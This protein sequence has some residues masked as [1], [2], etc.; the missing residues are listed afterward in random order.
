MRQ[1]KLILLLST[2]L[3]AEKTIDC[4]QVFDERRE[5]LLRELERIDE[6]QQAF[7][8]F[9]SA[10]NALLDKREEKVKAKEAEVSAILDETKD[11]EEHIQK[12]LDENKK[13][14]EEIKKAK[15]NKIGETFAKM[16]ASKAAPILDE[17]KASKASA[18]L[19]NLDPKTLG[20]LLSKMDPSKASTVVNLIKLGPP[21][22]EKE[23]IAYD[24][25]YLED[26]IKSKINS[27]KPN[28]N[29]NGVIDNA[30]DPQIENMMGDF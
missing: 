15:D 22:K 14:L 13:M 6:S 1:L 26:K 19:F 9:K 29:G 28:V 20:K 4:N 12:M 27:Y 2:L 10:T 7:E 30:K 5:E 21:F 11:R 18:I 24:K 16:K 8:A 23:V 25:Q 17:M 3:F